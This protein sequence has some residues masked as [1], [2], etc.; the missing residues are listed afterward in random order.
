MANLKLTL[1]KTAINITKTE[2]KKK[3]KGSYNSVL[4]IFTEV[5]IKQNE[6]GHLKGVSAHCTQS[7]H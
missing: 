6:C 5:L 3:K 7:Q 2:N 4:E 1:G